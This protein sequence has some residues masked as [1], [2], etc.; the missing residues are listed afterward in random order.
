MSAILVETGGGVRGAEGH[1]EV[2]TDGSAAVPGSRTSLPEVPLEAWPEAPDVLPN[3]K[4][5]FDLAP[6]RHFLYPAILLLLAEQPRHGYALTGALASLGLGRVDRPSIYRALSELER[7][8]LVMSWNEPPTA[9]S[10]RHVNALTPE[11]I[12]A[13]E[14][15]MSVIAQERASLD[16]VLQR[17]WYCNARRLLSPTGEPSDLD[18]SRLPALSQ[19]EPGTG[20]VADAPVRF[21]VAPDRSSLVVEARSN[22][23]PIAFITTSLTGWIE[24]ELYDGLVG[25]DPPPSAHLETR[26]TDLAS[27]NALYD[28]ELLRRIDARRFPTV[29]LDLSRCHRMGVGNCYRID[30]EVT[31]HG[32]TRHLSGAVTA[33]ILESPRRKVNGASTL[34]RRIVIAGEHVLDIRHFDMAI[35]ARP[36]LKLYPD[37]RLHLRLEADAVN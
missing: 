3:S 27:G 22:I 6:P 37:V 21:E 18:E 28:A 24:A 4:A 29:K 23:G 15:W 10:T 30:G 14:A 12:Q 26:V 17:Y 1:T 13:L 16:L 9:G 2:T 20:G 32:V 19:R 5:R 33:T 11:G 25:E 31:M 35:P 8:R 7:D 36:M 34:D